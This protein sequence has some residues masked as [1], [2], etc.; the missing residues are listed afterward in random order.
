MSEPD[1]LYL[2]DAAARAGLSYRNYGEFIGTLSAADV[3]AVNE[4]KGKV[5]PDVSP[6]VVAVPTKAPLEDHFNPAFRA[7]DMW[8]PDAMTPDSYMSAKASAG[9]LDPVI[10]PEHRDA[11][12]RGTSRLGV[13]LKDFRGFVED[14]E[15]G[16][17]DRMP[18]LSIM[19]LPN[20]H[21]SGLTQQHATPQFLVADNDYALG[22]VV[23]AVSHSPYWKST[24]ILVVEDDAQDGP[25]HVDA[26]RSPVLVISAYNRPGQLVHAVH[27]TVSLI[28]TLELLL[29]IQPMNII[30]ASAAPMDVFQDRPD[31]TPYTAQL[32]DVAG[33]NL[34]FHGPTT[35]QERHWTKETSRLVLTVPDAADPRV[36]NEVIWFSVRG[37]SRP[38]P[39]PAR[40]ALVDAMRSGIDEAGQEAA[41]APLRLAM[42]ALRQSRP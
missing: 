4:R 32:P 24:A 6:T 12:F 39:A 16:N 41:R 23:E 33:D 27:N 10:C 7:F 14:L 19:H 13:L 18:S 42:R 35:A 3:A 36:L 15:A 1:S 31:L 34:I 8:T 9:A 38:M 20:D 30:D 2:W 11:R 40:S 21:T 17:G 5:Y 22:R 37:G 29:G 28:R 26:H 25:D